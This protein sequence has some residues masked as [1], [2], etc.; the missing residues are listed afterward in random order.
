MLA[1]RVGDL[2]VH[3]SGGARALIGNFFGPFS[4]VPSTA[5]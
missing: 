3:P 4:T 2:V 1:Q 5:R